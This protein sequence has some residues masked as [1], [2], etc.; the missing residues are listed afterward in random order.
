MDPRYFQAGPD[1]GF[2]HR[3]L[4]A[5]TRVLVSKTDSGRS[6][7]NAPLLLGYAATSAMTPLYYPQVNRNFKDVASG[8]GGSL[9][10]AAIGFLF[11]EFSDSVLQSLHLEKRP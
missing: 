10:G 5:V 8:Y 6:S 4:Y 9:G 11:S 3:T 1:A 2:V 7:V